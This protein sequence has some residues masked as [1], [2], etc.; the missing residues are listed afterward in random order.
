MCYLYDVASKKCHL[1]NKNDT[2]KVCGNKPKS[3]TLWW[4]MVELT[5]PSSI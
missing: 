3:K 1:K 4:L 2:Q 5:S